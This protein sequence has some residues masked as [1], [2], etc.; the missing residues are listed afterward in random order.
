MKINKYMSFVWL[1][2][3]TSIVRRDLWGG[4]AMILVAGHV[5]NV[6]AIEMKNALSFSPMII[7][8]SQSDF[9]GGV[10]L[11]VTNDSDNV[12]LLKGSVKRMDP[13]TGR[14][15]KK[16]DSTP[17][18]V[19]I[20]PPLARIDANGKYIFRIRGISSDL[21]RDR[22]SAYIVSVTAIPSDK[23]RVYP[24]V[25]T[26]GSVSSNRKTSDSHDEKMS[27]K[28]QVAL[29]MN[30]RLFYRPTEVPERDNESVA[31]S[32]KFSV[33]GKN[34][35]VE[36]PTPYF[37]HLNDVSINKK[38]IPYDFLDGYVKPLSRRVFLLNQSVDKKGTLSWRFFGDKNIRYAPVTSI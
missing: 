21:P 3:T 15:N 22:E 28:L 12:Y 10:S 24:E 26:D 9:K 4:L 25:S 34:L 30:I 33:D 14:D 8:Y 7:N 23:N 13:D 38:N 31:K 2:F 20:L 36:N 37:I 17:S 16:D 6:F 11:T 18:S 5:N 32:L 29:R 19:V 27:G 35:V 1:A